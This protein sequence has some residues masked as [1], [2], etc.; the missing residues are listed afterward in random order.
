MIKSYLEVLILIMSFYNKNDIRKCTHSLNILK[1]A[2]KSI[3]LMF[4]SFASK[5]LNIHNMLILQSLRI[6]ICDFY[7]FVMI[8]GSNEEIIIS[9]KECCCQSKN[10][11]ILLFNLKGFYISNCNFSHLG[12]ISQG[13]W[14]FGVFLLVFGKKPLFR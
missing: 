5:S 11:Q 14:E 8:L 9:D 7:S 1:N 13:L 4:Y 3:S 2:K 12:C 6:Q 10:N